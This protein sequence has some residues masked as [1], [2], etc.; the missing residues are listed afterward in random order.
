MIIWWSKSNEIWMRCEMSE[1][2]GREK[3]D[4]RGEFKAGES[5][6]IWQHLQYF[7]LCTRQHLYIFSPWVFRPIFFS[8]SPGPKSEYKRNWRNSDKLPSKAGETAAF[9]HL[10]TMPPD[11]KENAGSLSRWLAPRQRLKSAACFFF[12]SR[13]CFVHHIYIYQP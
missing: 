6:E 4:G 12:L 5:F 1:M 8:K 13:V 11:P 2:Q 9:R 10:A 7:A 3:T